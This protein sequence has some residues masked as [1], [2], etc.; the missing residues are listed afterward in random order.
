MHNYVHTAW[1]EHFTAASCDIKAV[2]ISIKKTNKYL[3]WLDEKACTNI[4]K[5]DS[6]QFYLLCNILCW[7]IK[8]AW[9]PTLHCHCGTNVTQN[10]SK[11]ASNQTN[12]KISSIAC[13][14]QYKHA[15]VQHTTGHRNTAKKAHQRPAICFCGTTLMC[16]LNITQSYWKCY[17]GLLLMITG[18]YGRT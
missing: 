14:F 7:K 10:S 9:L 4:C 13:R 18:Y 11:S 12:N 17:Q 16:D 1:T 15:N 5:T 8:S 6:L 2:L 3:L